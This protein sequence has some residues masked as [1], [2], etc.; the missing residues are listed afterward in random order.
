MFPRVRCDPGAT[1]PS[2]DTERQL[3]NQDVGWLGKHSFSS[4]V[5][6]ETS[7]Q[8]LR[9]NRLAFPDFGT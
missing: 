5:G 3:G 9:S 8:A 4:E 1:E 6:T 7:L 2:L